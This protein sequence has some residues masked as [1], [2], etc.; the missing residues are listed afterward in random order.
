MY[1]QFALTIVI[2]VLISAFNALS[3][4]PALAAKLLRP[5][6][7]SHGPL[8]RFFDWFNRVFGDATNS[9]VRYSGALIRKSALSLMML[10]V[11][12][13]VA[14]LIG[15]RLPSSFLPEEDQ[16][17]CYV[18]VQLPLAA[19]LDRTDAVCKKVEDILQKTPGVRYYATI[20]GFSSIGQV[21]NTYSA[22]FFVTLK[23][24]DER[25]KPE[26]RYKNILSHVNDELGRM[27]EA[28]A[29]CF[30]AA[31]DSRHRRVGRLHLHS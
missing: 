30:L 22:T 29:V 11:V 18:N 3:L 8:R 1:Q 23:P 12:A 5:Q 2:S 21:Q 20:M 14:L 31:G 27:T 13:G 4:S 26:E 17:Y 6:K 25:T 7:A 9:Y 15:G 24:W 16:G 28:S 19:S 10:I